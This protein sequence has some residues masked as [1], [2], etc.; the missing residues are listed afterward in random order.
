[1]KGLLKAP[2]GNISW[3][4][5]LEKGWVK[6]EYGKLTFVEPKLSGVLYLDESVIAL[7][8]KCFYGCKNL[9]NIILNDDLQLIG[10]YA[11]AMCKGLE[12]LTI[13]GSVTKIGVGITI[14][15]TGLQSIV[16]DPS[17]LFYKS[18]SNCILENDSII[19]GCAESS[20]RN[21]KS[22]EQYAFGGIKK[23]KWD[24]FNIDIVEENAFFSCDIN[25]LLISTDILSE[26]RVANNAFKSSRI[27][28]VTISGNVIYK[29]ESFCNAPVYKADEVMKV[30]FGGDIQE[31]AI[32]RGENSDEW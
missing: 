12:K 13:P 29:D 8:S 21:H 7:S 28:G 19:A 30:D 2:K 11:F 32:F 23:S 1:M 4:S 31:I 24:I 5:L 22:I 14:G 6:M 10:S 25:D 17:N 16:V 26:C 27:G 3:A 15:C 20:I 9:T 18:D